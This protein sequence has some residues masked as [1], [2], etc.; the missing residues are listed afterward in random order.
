MI[1]YF[2]HIANLSVSVIDDSYA[3]K[4]VEEVVREMDPFGSNLGIQGICI[5]SGSFTDNNGNEKK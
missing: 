4:I 3:Q 2:R 1:I 5:I